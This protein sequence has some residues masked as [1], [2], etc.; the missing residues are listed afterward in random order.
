MK[1]QLID[2][3]LSLYDRGLLTK[4]PEEFDYGWVMSHKG[5]CEYCAKRSLK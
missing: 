2:F 3:M 5:N 1:K 4:S